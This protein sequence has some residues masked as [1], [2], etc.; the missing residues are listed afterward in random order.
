MKASPDLHRVAPDWAAAIDKAEEP[1]DLNYGAGPRGEDGLRRSL[2]DTGRC[3]VGE[4][5]LGKRGWKKCR[6]CDDF[7]WAF[8]NPDTVVEKE[9]EFAKHY[10]K[11]HAKQ[12]KKER[13]PEMPA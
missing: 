3:V 6:T 9:R 8:A 5:W 12:A 1:S 11:A 10:L 4:A 2:M 13:L 7:M